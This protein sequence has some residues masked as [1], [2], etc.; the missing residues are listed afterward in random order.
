[1]KII[2]GHPTPPPP[3]WFYD[4][5]ESPQL[6]HEPKCPNSSPNKKTQ[7]PKGDEFQQECQKDEAGASENR[8]RFWTLTIQTPQGQKF[9]SV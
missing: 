5:I 3:Q 8:I 7:G 2:I 4:Q 1:L 9:A 6:L